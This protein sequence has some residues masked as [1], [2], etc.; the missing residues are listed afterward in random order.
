MFFDSS[1]RLGIVNAYALPTEA[2]CRLCASQAK[3]TSG[4]VEGHRELEGFQNPCEVLERSRELPSAFVN[5]W[6]FV[7]RKNPVV[8][9]K[10]YDALLG[11]MHLCTKNIPRKEKKSKNDVFGLIKKYDAFWGINKNDLAGITNYC[12]FSK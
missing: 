6:M 8:N 2:Q 1:T 11:G 3:N 9:G 7:G 4:F 12:Y 5:C 10:K